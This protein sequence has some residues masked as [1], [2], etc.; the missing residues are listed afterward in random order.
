M[1]LLL[2]HYFIYYYLDYAFLLTIIC[3]IITNINNIYYQHWFLISKSK[4]AH[5]AQFMVS[6]Y[7]SP[8]KGTKEPWAK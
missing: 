4:K 6:K 5:S 1:F 7:Y 3:F 8:V 2:L